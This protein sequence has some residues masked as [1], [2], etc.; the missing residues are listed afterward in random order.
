[1]EHHRKLVHHDTWGHSSIL[2]HDFCTSIP[3]RQSTELAKCRD[4]DV[5]PRRPTWLGDTELKSWD[6]VEHQL[7][8]SRKASIVSCMQEPHYAF[9]PLSSLLWQPHILEY[10][11]PIPCL[12]PD[13]QPTIEHTIFVTVCRSKRVPK[14]PNQRTFRMNS[15][16]KTRIWEIYLLTLTNFREKRTRSIESLSFG[17]K[18][19]PYDD[20]RG[21][22]NSC[23]D[24]VVTGFVGSNPWPCWISCWESKTTW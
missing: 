10:S 1:M 5:L 22:W 16:V 23:S 20:G 24:I 8:W 12:A 21:E 14:A 17:L 6:D 15:N 18:G 11:K 9:L 4:L 7:I 2:G 3:L 13:V 19:P